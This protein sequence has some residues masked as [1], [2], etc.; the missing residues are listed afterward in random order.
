[1]VFRPLMLADGP[2]VD[3]TAFKGLITTTQTTSIMHPCLFLR[4]YE[5]FHMYASEIGLQVL[6]MNTSASRSKAIAKILARVLRL[7]GIQ[8]ACRFGPA[9]EWVFS[10]I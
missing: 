9:L 8:V 5:D 2:P 3:K 7:A 6:V 1:M 10:L 4:V